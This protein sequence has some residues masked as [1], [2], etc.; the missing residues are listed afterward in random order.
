MKEITIA[1]VCVNALTEADMVTITPEIA[2]E[3]LNQDNENFRK[4]SKAEVNRHSSSMLRGEWRYNGDSIAINNQGLVKDGQHRL[5]GC[6]TSKIPLKTF[7]IRIGS[8][9]NI[10]TKKK[11]GFD[12]IIQGLGHRNQIALAATIKTLYR[13]EH[14]I[15]TFF[16]SKVEIENNQLITFF[17]ENPDILDS[18]NFTMTY[19]H[20][21]D[22]PH[23]TLA[24]FYHITKQLDINLA[25]S[26]IHTLSLPLKDYER[27]NIS[28]FNSV[29]HLKHMLDSPNEDQKI[30]IPIKIA[31]L[32]KAWNHWRDE[33]ICQRLKWS[34]SGANPEAFPEIK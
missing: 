17:N 18:F 25:R 22:M 8:D 10:D 23:S 31:V 32:I 2:D 33:S 16:I 29:Y 13:Y 19:Y 15:P 27:L 7:L 6:K 14:H 30:P 26:F 34:V 4:I 24:A 1:G 9:M 21:C 20:K 11:L 5:L 28:V 3:L 12:K